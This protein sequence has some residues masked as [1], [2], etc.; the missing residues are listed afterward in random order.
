MKGAVGSEISAQPAIDAA[1]AAIEAVKKQ[2]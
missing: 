2:K 1:A